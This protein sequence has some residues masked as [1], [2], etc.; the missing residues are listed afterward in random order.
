MGAGWEWGRGKVT[1]IKTATANTASIG[2]TGDHSEYLVGP[3][4][5]IKTY[6]FNHFY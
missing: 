4:V 1:F 6:I 3:M 5:Y 2:I